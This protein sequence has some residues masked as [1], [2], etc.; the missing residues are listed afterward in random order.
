M[1]RDDL[2]PSKE[3]VKGGLGYDDLRSGCYEWYVAQIRPN[4]RNLLDDLIQPIQC[5]WS[6]S[7]LAR[8]DMTPPGIC[9][10]SIRQSTPLYG[11]SKSLYSALTALASSAAIVSFARSQ[12][13]S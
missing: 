12:P 9:V 2:V 4:P 8:L 13:V 10:T 3:N 5:V 1:V 7:W 6:L 11:A